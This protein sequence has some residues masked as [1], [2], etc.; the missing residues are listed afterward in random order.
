VRIREGLHNLGSLAGEPTRS[1]GG[2]MMQQR[3]DGQRFWV[4]PGTQMV[5]SSCEQRSERAS[6]VCVQLMTKIDKIAILPARLV[7][8]VRQIDQTGPLY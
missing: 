7:R 4:E 6:I 8:P 1:S 2:G 5:R 3:T